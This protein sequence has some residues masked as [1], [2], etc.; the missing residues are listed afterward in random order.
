MNKSVFSRR[1]FLKG[2]AV[3]VTALALSA[4][5]GGNETVHYP[6]QTKTLFLGTLK[7]EIVAPFVHS[8]NNR[9]NVEFRF[10]ITNNSDTPVTLSSDNFLFKFN[11]QPVSLSENK[12]SNSSLPYLFDNM[13][14]PENQSVTGYLL[15][16]SE[17]AEGHYQVTVCYLDKSDTFDFT[18]GPQEWYE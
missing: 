11:D 16:P 5:G 4:C 10:R 2:S 14:I 18:Y 9:T 6:A 12:L 13:P 15:I 8:E 17:K 3:A 7:I 1:V